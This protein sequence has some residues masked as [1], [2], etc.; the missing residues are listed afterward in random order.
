[1]F[2]EGQDIQLCMR[3]ADSFKTGK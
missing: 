3:I 1:M 2:G